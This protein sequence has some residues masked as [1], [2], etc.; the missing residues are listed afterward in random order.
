MNAY[1][2][3]G[4]QQAPTSGTPLVGHGAPRWTT[5]AESVEAIQA[6]L[7]GGLAGVA[8]GGLSVAGLMR[9]RSGAGMPSEPPVPAP[10]GES[11]VP[12]G[13][14]AVLAVLRSSA[15]I[16][17]RAERVVASSPG[18]AAV[19]V[20][21]VEGDRLAAN[22]LRLLVREVLESGAIRE[23]E[24]RQAGRLGVPPRTL[25]I[26]IAP[27][28]TDH[29]LVLAEDRSSA[30][31]LDEVRR[32]FVV[33]VSHELK[34]PVG[35]LSLLA[36]A[37]ADAKD[38]PE[39]IERFASRMQLESARLGKLIKEI[40]D[41]SRLEATAGIKEPSEVPVSKVV[42]E[43]VL[44]SQVEADAKSIRLVE[45]LDPAAVVSGDYTL[46]VT[47]VRNL[48]DNAIAY[49]PEGTEVGIGST[50]SGDWVRI[51]VADRGQGIPR[52]EQERIFERF[53]RID[54]ARSRN[55]GGTG[56]GLAI[57]KHICVN[58]GG[59]VTLWSQ[60]G[61]GSTFTIRLPL[62]AAAASSHRIEGSTT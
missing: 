18:A 8:L 22:D 1:R 24:L 50:V 33:N 10:R 7:I 35:G 61:K 53:Y 51:T 29:V 42:Q 45:K 30:R 32:D 60:E 44:L 40:V 59:E 11:A 46:L 36:E 54:A 34:T 62:S 16:L 31:R 12:E 3:A 20:G 5:Y 2:P 15:L 25:H 13:A 26:R 49:S 47:A 38:D 4:E 6:A 9:G 14:G 55:T 39:A 57:V 41:L 23:T 27:L 56:L 58:H 17:D 19:G 52:A 28:L 37:I 43:A 48:I 21:L